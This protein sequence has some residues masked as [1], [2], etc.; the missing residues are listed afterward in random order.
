MTQ[1]CWLHAQGV[2][3]RLTVVMYRCA[4]LSPRCYSPLPNAISTGVMHPHGDKATAVMRVDTLFCLIQR[5]SR[6]KV[7]FFRC[8]SLMQDHSIGY[9]AGESSL[10]GSSRQNTPGLGVHCHFV[11]FSISRLS[12][13]NNTCSGRPVPPANQDCWCRTI[14]LMA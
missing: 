8:W 3:L 13:K 2:K 1:T 5:R 4:V 14:M 6:Y 9:H 7:V 11:K 12:V 10:L